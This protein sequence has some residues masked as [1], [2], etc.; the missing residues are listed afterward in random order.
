METTR[1]WQESCAKGMS[2]LTKLMWILCEYQSVGYDDKDHTRCAT[3]ADWFTPMRG[4]HGTAV[5]CVCAH[6]GE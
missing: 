5:R 3:V 4:N 1:P 2:T 6:L